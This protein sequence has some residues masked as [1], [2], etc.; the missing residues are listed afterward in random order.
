MQGT[1]NRLIVKIDKNLLKQKREK[2]GNFYVPEH[3]M[4]FTNN[5]QF[6]QVESFGYGVKKIM[7]DIEVG[8]IAIFD[9]AV[10]HQ[11]VGA[12]RKATDEDKFLIGTEGDF[13]YR[14]VNVHK[15]QSSKLF[16]IFKN[17]VII[18]S[19]GMV[20]CSSK[21]KITGYQLNSAGL[22]IC[23]EKAKEPIKDALE[24]AKHGRSEYFR[25]LKGIKTNAETYK[26]KEEIIGYIREFDNQMNRLTAQLNAIELAELTVLFTNPKDTLEIERGDTVLLDEKMVYP[27]ELFGSRFLIIRNHD[28]IVAKI[29]K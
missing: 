3:L 14:V 9:H 28:W 5:L 25:A 8:D 26:L 17:E 12:D 19:P 10:E 6:A 13:E 15:D 27:I 20:F 7:P 2:I 18:P 24:V 21:A 4:D 22:Y 11:V 29:A 1:D 23:S 16:G